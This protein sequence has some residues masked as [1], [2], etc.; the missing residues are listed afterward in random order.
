MTAFPGIL[1]TPPGMTRGANTTDDDEFGLIASRVAEQMGSARSASQASQTK[2]ATDV[3]SRPQ[4]TRAVQ[5]VENRDGTITRTET[6]KNAP[7]SDP[8]AEVARA[9]N[10]PYA[11]M[12]T[13]IL[14]DAAEIAAEQQT[15]F[16]ELQADP[17]WKTPEGRRELARQ[18]GVMDPAAEPGGFVRRGLFKYRAD[19]RAYEDLIADPYR[20]RA[21][22]LANEFQKRTDLGKSVAPYSND[23]AAIETRSR[24]NAAD[25]RQEDRAN[26]AERKNAIIDLTRVDTSNF[27]NADKVVD[28]MKM[29]YSPDEWEEVRGYIEPAARIKYASDMRAR[30]IANAKLTIQENDAKIRQLRENRQDERSDATLEHLTLA[31]ERLRQIIEKGENPTVKKIKTFAGWSASDIIEAVGNDD[32]DQDALGR[33]ANSRLTELSNDINTNNGKIRTLT[34]EIRSM[35]KNEAWKVTDIATKKTRLQTL[36]D[37]NDRLR[38]ETDRL[39]GAG[40]GGHDTKPAP[41]ESK[42]APKATNRKLKYVPGKG[43]QSQ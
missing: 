5:I 27:E 31:N 35:E 28:W 7:K 16:D 11:Q 37:D 2:A 22:V 38:K 1:Y 42:P 24:L 39:L 17:R 10:E 9:A 19:R 29:G 25:A 18:F 13:G 33:K 15:R 8:A 20:L 23:L 43:L 34:T 21:T 32:V 3:A 41:R 26:A 6:V 4:P 40:F 14:K 30:E 36:I 12:A